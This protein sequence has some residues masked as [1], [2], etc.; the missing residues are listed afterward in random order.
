MD[1]R[2]YHVA[3]R[4]GHLASVYEYP[5]VAENVLGKLDACR[6]EHCG[7]YDGMEADYLFSDQMEIR[8]PELLE[9]G[10]V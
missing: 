6:H 4:F 7:P 5:A 1:H 2:V 10:C 3:L 9:E 8:R